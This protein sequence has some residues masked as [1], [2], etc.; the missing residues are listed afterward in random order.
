MT[1]F[2]IRRATTLTV[3]VLLT[4]TTVVLA[5]RPPDSPCPGT[6]KEVISDN[7]FKFDCPITWI[8]VPADGKAMTVKLDGQPAPNGVRSLKPGMKATVTWVT[9]ADE[10][11]TMRVTVVE[12]SSR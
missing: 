8:C 11:R 9:F 1:L 2:P 4:V 7:S 12:A 3:A 5:E 10:D 6:V